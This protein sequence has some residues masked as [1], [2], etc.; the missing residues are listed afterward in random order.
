VEAR[1]RKLEVLTRLSRLAIACSI[2]CCIV[3]GTL[4]VSALA[5]TQGGPGTA[6]GRLTLNGKSIT[7]AHAYA[8][9]QPGF[10]D[11]TKEDIHILLSNV[12][13][14][15]KDREDVFS[16]MKLADEGRAS[17]V[18]VV[19][20]A[21]GKPIGGQLFAKPFTGSVSV[22]GMHEFTKERMEPKIIAG[23]LTSG[24]PH[25][26]MK[27]TWEYDARFSAA[28]PRPPTAEETAAALA[29]PAAKAA[30]AYLAAMRQG[31][32]PA[33]LATLDATAAADYRGADGAA[34]L[35]QLQADFP[36]DAKVV[37]VT[38]QPDGTARAEVEGKQDG[39]VIAYTLKMVMA[40][41]AWKVGK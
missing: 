13:L 4:A 11:K 28:I 7:L 27:V 35:K 22:A 20:D 31:Q 40:G 16:L 5:Q 14:S 39:V 33:F 23:R 2:V 15:D 30:S 21:E 32:L 37:G 8:S 17:M 26:F 1:R 6:T 10:F 9:A 3:C 19:I 29:S 36:P 41:G 18:E 24:G 12:P 38:M 25:E 34:K